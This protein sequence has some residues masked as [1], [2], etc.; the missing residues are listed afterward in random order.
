[1][2]KHLGTDSMVAFPKIW[3]H[4]C[5][6]HVVL[7]TRLSIFSRSKKIT[8]CFVMPLDTILWGTFLWATYVH[9]QCHQ[10]TSIVKALYIQNKIHRVTMQ[11]YLFYLLVFCLGSLFMCETTTLIFF[12]FSFVFSEITPLPQGV[13]TEICTY[14][15]IRNMYINNSSYSQAMK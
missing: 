15:E 9:F 1:M 11:T 14:S 2:E 3:R 7:C 5:K 12:L 4:V 8:V 6:C 13:H 10:D